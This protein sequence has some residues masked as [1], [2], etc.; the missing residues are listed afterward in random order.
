MVLTERRH[1]D[2]LGGALAALER[3]LGAQAGGDPLE[4]LALEMREAWPPSARS[5]GRPPRTL[6]LEQI[7]SRFCIGK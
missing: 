2:A 1:R 6:I 7:F 5:P 3:F 4:C